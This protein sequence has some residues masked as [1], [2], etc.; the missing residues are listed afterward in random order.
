MRK[1]FFVLL[2]G[3]W[4][5]FNYSYPS[6]FDFYPG[7][8]YKPDIPTLN[9]IVGH[10]WGEQIT[11]HAEMERYLRALA[12]AATSKIKVVEYG[13]TWEA[14]TLYYLV[15]A[16][17]ENMARL[18][19]IRSGMQ[20][21]ADP[22][23]TSKAEAEN[24]IKTLPSVA[25]LA[26]SVHGD[27]ISSTDAAL[28][29]AYHLIAAQNDTLAE[30][31][32]NN[33]VVI[34]DPLQN[35]D[36][37][38]RF[39]QYYQ[40][41]RGRWPDP[42]QQAAEHN[43]DWPSG[44]MNHYLFDMNRDW[45]ALTQP[46]T[47][48]RV[49]A[50]LEWYPQVYVDLHEMGAN[51]TYYFPPPAAPLNP[52]LT[53]SQSQWLERFGRKNAKWF[54]RLRFDYFTREIF[55]SFYPGYGEGWPMFHG[56]IGMTYEQASTKG[57]VVQREDELTLHYREAVQHHFISS[58]STLETA[59]RHH[60]ALLRYFY[61]YRQSAIQDGA[62]DPNNEFILPPGRDLNRVKKL[63]L[64]LINQGIEVKKAEAPF[65]N[66]RVKDYFNDRMQS[67]EFPAGTYLVSL[68]QPAKRLAK[69]L[70][71]RHTPMDETFRQEQIR[72]YQKR[73]PDEIYDITGWSLPL[74][75]D[76]EMYM[77][78]VPSTGRFIMLSQ[79]EKG[80]GQIKGGTTSLVYLIPWSS[81]SAAFALAQIHR[82]NLR[83]YS[84]DKAFSLNGVQFP[85]GTLII[86][87]KENPA[88]LHERLQKMAE[89]TGVEIVATSSSWVQEGV[90]FGSERVN[91]LK[92]PKIALA[93]HQPTHPYSAG[94][95]RYVLEQQYGYPVTIINTQ[96]MSNMDL[97]KYN[98]VILPNSAS[99]FGDYGKMFGESEV[100]KFK[101]WLQN[102][103]TLITFGEATRWLTEEKVK[104]LET[105]PEYRGGKPV[106][107]KKKSEKTPEGEPPAE[108]E[109]PSVAPPI[110]PFDFERAILPEDE[111]P[112][113]T[114]GALMRVTLDTEHWL[115]FGYD[116]DATVLVQSR[117]IFTPIKLDKG[118]NVGVFMKENE[119]LLSGF[120][121][122]DGHKQIANKAYLLYQPH[123][124][125][126]VVAFA[127]DPNFRAFADGLN[128]LFLNAIF[129][130]P[131]H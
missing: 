109:S 123:G 22:R 53:P 19:A 40:Q 82:Q 1:V 71:A 36:G 38:E 128:L 119:V 27:E 130:G 66:A 65:R 102:G 117:N 73:L 33:T 57:L 32:L 49:R 95:T 86:K 76:V 77:A 47:R 52:E 72:R 108:P 42:D 104:L 50:F 91:F 64:L 17:D 84:S 94:W 70:L 37:R 9:Q 115:A 25:W 81:N 41:T 30:M 35:P 110:E 14:R 55:D 31:V 92:K 127:E 34:I 10:A 11:T 18:E 68:A 105:T 100:N 13:Q 96:Q 46:E 122:E 54:D 112:A 24:L 83:V 111:L 120:T 44:R 99:F 80:V 101:S 43:E 98:V 8:T 107:P 29:T 126:H 124:S 48:G 97:N 5:L 67:K 4:G 63:V 62:R 7:A 39:I 15:V 116:G 59:A 45:F 129:F 125:G 58:L 131:A 106:K 85:S 118:R 20:K 90:N 21:L 26:Y 2:I 89:D 69:T 74:L 51:S 78:E 113:A 87:V 88:D 61:D 6:D 79:P 12:A 103:G 75:F 28:L 121:W 60:E 93:Y 16:S 23:K 3:F 56:A 114:P